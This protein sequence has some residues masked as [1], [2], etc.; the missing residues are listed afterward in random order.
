MIY[1]IFKLFTIWVS[2]TQICQFLF[3]MYC[4]ELNQYSKS[5]GQANN[6]KSETIISLN[7][8]PNLSITTLH[9]LPEAVRYLFLLALNV[10]RN[11]L[12]CIY[13]MYTGYTL[14]GRDLLLRIGYILSLGVTLPYQSS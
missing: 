4:S 3:N 5:N 8:S 11:S 7:L 14:F 6:W 13:S 1:A 2:L 12:S 9:H 10:F